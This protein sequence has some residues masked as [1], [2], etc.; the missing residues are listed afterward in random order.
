MLT[1]S[2][3]AARALHLA[4]QG[5]LTPPRRKATKSDV[6]DTIRRMAQLQIDTIHVVARSPYLVLFSRL[7][8]FS[9]QWLDEHLAEARLFEYWSHEACFLPIE[10]FGLMR[11]KMLDPSGMGWK[12]AA[13]WHAQNRPEIERLLAWIR[14]EGPVRSADFARE[15]GVKGN[16]WWDRKPEKRH[17]EVLFTTGDLMVS[18][19]RNFQ[20]VYDVRERVLPGWDDTRDL[21]PREAV[22]PTLLDYTCRALGVVRADWVA[23][24]YRLPRRSYRAELERL[25]EAGDLIPVQIDDWKEP[26]YVHRSLDAWL[27]AAAADTLRSTVTTLLSPFDPVVWDRRRASTLFGFD[28]TIECYTPEHKRRYGYFCLPVLHRGRLV[29]RV[30]AK[31]HRTLGTFELKAVHVEP[32]VRFG[33]G[34]AADVA[35]AV[36]KLAAWHGTPEVTVRHAPPEL[37]KALADT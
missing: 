36:K 33:T 34:L 14:A 26:A 4:A 22:L 29:G 8:D 13:E 19:R 11:Y 28:Y 37:V 15:D 2:P 24:Y 9:P 17:L 10:Q 5:L 20:R 32:G 31:A 1:L 27:P 16:G 7:G 30:D 3:A 18:E 23:D 25:A 35:K 6:L 21:P 12:Y